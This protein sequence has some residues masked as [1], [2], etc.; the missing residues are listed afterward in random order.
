MAWASNSKVVWKLDGRE[1]AAGCFIDIVQETWQQPTVHVEHVRLPWHA[2]IT[3]RIYSTMCVWSLLSIKLN[4][5]RVASLA[6][7]ENPVLM[8][9]IETCLPKKSSWWKLKRKHYVAIL[10]DAEI[11]EKHLVGLGNGSA[12]GSNVH[13][14]SLHHSVREA[15]FQDICLIDSVRAHGFKIPSLQRGWSFWGHCWRKPLLATM[16]VHCT[17]RDLVCFREK[18]SE[19]WVRGSLTFRRF[20]YVKNKQN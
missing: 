2:K 11:K 9:C 6:A 5:G 19:K 14:G 16:S 3:Q 13:T 8:V 20:F 18:S 10:N 17:H 4:V 1:C 7:V 12:M 15:T